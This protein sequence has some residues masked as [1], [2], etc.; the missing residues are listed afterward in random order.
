MTE[1]ISDP[2]IH[3]WIYSRGT[4]SID[5]SNGICAS[6]LMAGLFTIAKIWKQLKGPSTDVLTKENPLRGDGPLRDRVCGTSTSAF[7]TTRTEKQTPIV[8]S[9]SSL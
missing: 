8:F 4:E 9:L 5:M 2:A 6:S 3:P 1:I 7:P